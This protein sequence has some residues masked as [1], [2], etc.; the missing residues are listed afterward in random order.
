[1]K[2]VARKG[3]KL[4]KGGV[5]VTAS[6]DVGSDGI[7]VA[8]VGDT[9]SCKKHGIKK[10]ASGASSVS[11]NSKPT[12]RIGDKTTCGCT[13]ITGSS[14][15]LVGNSTGGGG[16][17]PAPSAQFTKPPDT[18]VKIPPATE[19][20]NAV[21]HVAYV[22]NPGASRNRVAAEN[23]VKE[24][25]AGTPDTDGIE[26]TEP[27]KKCSNGHDA[28]VL[29]FLNR[30][31]GEAAKGQ[32]RETGQR[33]NP[34][35]QNIINIWKSLGYPS[36]GMWASDQTAWCAGFVNWALKE[37]GLPYSKEAGAR[38]TVSKAPGL[39]FTTVAISDMQPGDI[40]LW[41]FS[42]VNFCYT[43]S[44]GKYTFVGGNQTPDDKT[45]NNNPSDGSVTISWKSGW[46]PARGGIVAVVRPQCK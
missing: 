18:P 7:P 31:L 10:I 24:N 27:P 26:D 15:R 1:M 29:G 21:A 17:V 16:S 37:C 30:I 44:G 45:K 5:I 12:A 3:D 33:G 6:G 43:A 13:I 35:N 41:S 4:S 22:N 32:W 36:S 42:H 11:T 46:T 8:R 20:K 34:S 25:Y 39:G 2:G 28:N 38:N 23:G 9:V 19:Q 40:V 14:K